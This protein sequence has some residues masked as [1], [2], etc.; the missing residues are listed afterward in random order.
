MVIMNSEKLDGGD[1]MNDTCF[2]TIYLQCCTGCGIVE[3][4][5]KYEPDEFYPVEHEWMEEC[6]HST[7]DYE[8]KRDQNI[9]INYFGY[10]SV[11]CLSLIHI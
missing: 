3:C 6:F 10:C 4:A 1:Q 11:E 7:Y 5:Y 2:K 8:H 9:E